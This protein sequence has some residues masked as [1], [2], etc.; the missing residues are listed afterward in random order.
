VLHTIKGDF[1]RIENEQFLYGLNLKCLFHGRNVCPEL[2]LT[3]A[4]KVKSGTAIAET[5]A[6]DQ[7]STDVMQKRWPRQRIGNGGAD[8][9]AVMADRLTRIV[10]SFVARLKRRSPFDRNAVLSA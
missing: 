10:S 8:G 2:S 4:R 6:F 3:P 9:R 1:Y 5:N 7:S